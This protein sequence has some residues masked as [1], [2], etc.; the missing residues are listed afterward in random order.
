M[1]L[2]IQSGIRYFMVFEQ[3][4]LHKENYRVSSFDNSIVY[5]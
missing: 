4:K 1:V 2:Q 5:T 3:P